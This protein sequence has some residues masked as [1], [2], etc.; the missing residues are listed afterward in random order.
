MKNLCCGGFA[1]SRGSCSDFNIVAQKELRKHCPY[2]V[3]VNVL[4]CVC[5]KCFIG[6]FA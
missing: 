1:P 5:S 4:L 2:Q 6:V 3:Y